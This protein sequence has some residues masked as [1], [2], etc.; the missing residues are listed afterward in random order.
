M[1]KFLLVVLA[2]IFLSTLAFADKASDLAA[3][4]VVNPN[5][6]QR[7]GLR[8]QGDTCD[9]PFFAVVGDN[10]APYAPVWYE[11]TATMDGV[12]EVSSCVEGQYVDTYL[13]VYADCAQTNITENDDAYCTEYDYASKVTFEILNGVSYY[14]LWDDSWEATGFTWNITES[15]PVLPDEGDTFTNPIMINAFPYFNSGDSSFYTDTYNVSNPSPDVFFQFTTDTVLNIDIECCGSTFDTYLILFDDQQNVVAYNDDNCGPR[16]WIGGGDGTIVQPGTYVICLEGYWTSAGYYELNVGELMPPEFG[17]IDGTVFDSVTGLPIEGVTIYAGGLNQVTDASGYYEFAGLETGL[18]NVVADLATYFPQTV[19]GVEVFAEQTTTVDFDL[20]ARTY[21]MIDGTVV[22]EGTG[23]PIV[24]ATVGAGGMTQITDDMGYYLFDMVEIGTYNVTV[25][26][27]GFYSQTEN[28]VEVFTGQTTTVNFDLAVFNNIGDTILDP[29]VVDA[30]PY[31]M[32]GD[33]NL[34]TDYSTGAGLVGSHSGQDVFWE[35]IV[36]EPSMMDLSGCGSEFDTYMNLYDD[37]YTRIAYDDDGCDADPGSSLAAWIAVGNGFLVQPGTYYVCHE[38]YSLYPAY[39]YFEV[40][41]DILP[42][43]PGGTIDGTVTNLVTGDPIVGAN[44]TIDGTTLMTD[45]MGYYMST[46]ELGLYDISVAAAGY[47]VDEATGVEVLEDQTT[48]VDFALD[49]ISGVVF[50]ITCDMFWGEASWNVWDVDNQSLVWDTDFTF[51][52]GIETQTVSEDIPNGNYEVWCHDTYGDGGI[53]GVVSKDGIVLTQWSDLDYT[54]EG[55]FP[56]TV[57][58]PY[59]YGDV[60]GDELVDSFDAANILQYTVGMDP[61]GAPLPW[62]WE[63]IAGDVNG[64]GFSESFDA[65]LILQYAVGIIDVFPVEARID[66]P[67]ADVS[68]TVENGELVFSTTGDLYGFSLMTETDMISFQEPVVDYLHAISG[69]AIALA[70]AEAING[71]FL[72][73]P[74][75]KIA[76]N[77]EFTMTMTVNGVSTENTYNVEDLES[78][79]AVNAVLGNYPNPFNP[80]TTIKLAVKEDNTPVKVSIY[81]VKGQLVNSL[82]NEMAAGGV[83]DFV[84]SGNDNSN[85]PVSSGVYFYKVKIGSLNETHKMIM[86]K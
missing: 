30:F 15:D 19:M 48:T 6:G 13:Y 4:K 21:G 16:S 42:P 60:T 61:A 71:E 85:R 79:P 58:D 72:R 51:T 84:W 45:D 35:F 65:A 83:H 33:I 26:A 20:V 62:T 66:A 7:D 5:P 1:K 81:N 2:L 53:A 64:D 40:H 49:P 8:E 39:Q 82:V 54:D 78:A 44:V 68:M 38:G 28:G 63:L 9:D 34:Y 86:L 14:L 32:S 46:F 23:L 43:P 50:Q 3:N 29:I 69:N 80:S 73:I 67:I 76:E 22:E 25:L 74:F 47:N 52:E 24:G 41:F 59:I 36:T 12:A 55:V 56:F 11:Y 75:D 57:G 37:T 27:E 17:N 31:F 10:V 18:Y 77:G 70:S